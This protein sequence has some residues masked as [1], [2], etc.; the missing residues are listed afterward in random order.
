[1]LK[2][3]T[4]RKEDSMTQ[5]PSSLNLLIKL[6]M[7]SIL[8][9]VS[10]RLLVLVTVCRVL[11]LWHKTR[12]YLSEMMHKTIFDVGDYYFIEIQ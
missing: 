5:C 6:V 2:F 12:Y 10:S 3:K 4:Q 1:M 9:E 11:Q 7:I 8:V